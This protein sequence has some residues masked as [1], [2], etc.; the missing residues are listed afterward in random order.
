MSGTSV[1]ASLIEFFNAAWTWLTC[2]E[3]AN[4]LTNKDLWIAV[5][6]SLAGAAGG[7]LGAQHIAERGKKREELIKE[8]RSVNAALSVNHAL[9]NSVL[10]LKK[11]YLVDMKAAFIADKEGFKNHGEAYQLTPNFMF[12]QPQKYPT[13]TLRTLVFERV[14][15]IGRPINLVLQIAATLDNL[16]DS[17]TNR[18]KLISETKGT[19]LFNAAALRYFYLGVPNPNGEIDMQYPHMMDAMFVQTDDAIHFTELLAKDL[20]A[21]GEQLGEQYHKLFPKEPKLKVTKIDYTAPKAEGLFPD[22]AAYVSWETGFQKAG[23]PAAA[24][25][26]SA[27][28]P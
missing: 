20:Q 24:T 26:S 6:G 25:A 22:P 28:N 1:Y 21:H 15:V 27:G 5:I 12:L 13:D 11:Q 17:V 19:F 10:A 23:S 3:I 4:V 7:A 8:M 9:T 16:N 14:S 18:N 2:L